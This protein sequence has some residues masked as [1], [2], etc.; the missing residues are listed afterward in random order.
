MTAVSNVQEN[1]DGSHHGVKIEVI[2]S[3]P[4]GQ[5]ASFMPW[6][7]SFDHKL[8]MAQYGHQLTF[9]AICRDRGCAFLPSSALSVAHL[10]QS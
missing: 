8:A 6:T 10:T 4:G 2:Q 5:A 3:F 1:W 9:I 7:S